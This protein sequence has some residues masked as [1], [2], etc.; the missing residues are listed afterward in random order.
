MPLDLQAE[1]DLT[2]AG[3]QVPGLEPQAARAET[4]HPS[5]PLH[6]YLW[7]LWPREGKGMVWPHSPSSS[8]CLKVSESMAEKEGSIPTPSSLTAALL[9][10]PDSVSRCTG[11]NQ[12]LSWA[13]SQG[14]LQDDCRDL[15]LVRL[16]LSDLGTRSLEAAGGGCPL[17]RQS[18]YGLGIVAQVG[19][20]CPQQILS[21]RL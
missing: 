16:S 5:Q 15:L 19:L 8:K 18:L 12:P 6:S 14:F 9:K 2:G 13:H 3:L 1:S 7:K 20:G 4:A 11:Q 17:L 21:P 10:P